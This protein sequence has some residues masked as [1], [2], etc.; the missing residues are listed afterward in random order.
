MNDSLNIVKQYVQ[1]Y[2]DHDIQKIRQL[3]HSNY[4]S[5]S[6]SGQR[7]EGIEAG[8]NTASMYLSAFPDMKLDI[9]NIYSVGDVIVAEFISR[10]TQKGQY[11]G[12]APTG[13]QVS[14]PICDVIECRDGKIYSERDYFDS[15][16]ILQQLGVKTGTQGQA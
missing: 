8:I 14:I 16:L 10:G 6:N 9:K 7:H 11:L 5:A 13:R 4:S 3:L 12:I 1:A 2:S 15:S